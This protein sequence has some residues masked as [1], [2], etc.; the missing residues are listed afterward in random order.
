M[1]SLSEPVG[2]P[3]LP[4]GPEGAAIGPLMFLPL[5]L[6]AVSQA[7]VLSAIAPANSALILLWY[8]GFI[9]CASFV[10][11]RRGSCP[12]VL[13]LL[14]VSLLDREGQVLV[15]ARPWVRKTK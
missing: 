8:V 15:P 3:L 10:Q 1:W 14:P 7:A 11:S 2:L 5:M 9:V 6:G 12:C 4:M 13:A